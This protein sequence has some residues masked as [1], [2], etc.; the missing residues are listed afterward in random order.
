MMCFEIMLYFKIRVE[1]ASVPD[2]IEFASA[3]ACA[4]VSWKRAKSMSRHSTLCW[5]LHSATV[6]SGI[7]A[8]RQLPPLADRCT[9]LQCAVGRNY[10]RGRR[11]LECTQ[12]RQAAALDRRA[13]CTTHVPAACMLSPPRCTRLHLTKALRHKQVENNCL[14]DPPPLLFYL[15]S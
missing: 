5:L 4:R 1:H 8:R 10:V 15:F 3:R 13:V 6:C 7:C 14:D 2:L 11:N 9:S 12:K